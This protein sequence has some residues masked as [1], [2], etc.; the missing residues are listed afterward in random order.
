LHCIYAYAVTTLKAWHGWI[1]GG[2]QQHLAHLAASDARY[3]DARRQAEQA[4]SVD[5]AAAVA[6]H[7]QLQADE[8]WKE[9]N[10][11]LYVSCCAVHDR[12]TPLDRP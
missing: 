6:A 10:C 4:H 11:K 7:M 2:L 8:R 5:H 9:Q 3:A 1:A 12:S